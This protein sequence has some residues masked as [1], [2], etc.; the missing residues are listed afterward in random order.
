MVDL[1]YAALYFGDFEMA[2]EVGELEERMS[3]L[4]HE[5]RK[6][7]ILAVRNP[8]EAEAMSSVLQVISADRAHRQRR[9]RHRPH[10]H[11]QPRDPP[12]AASPT[13]RNAEE[14]SHRVVVREGSHMDH[15]PLADLELPTVTGFRVMAIRREREWVTDVERRR[16][17]HARR[18]AV[19]RRASRRASPDSASWRRRPSGNPRSPRITPPSPISTGPS[20]CSWR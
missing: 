15:R 14:V 16:G 17:A 11:P 13:C 10:R 5:M 1:A 9:G 18:R 4:V 7:C 19:P 2:E 3:E 20:T 8:R 6:V 12:R